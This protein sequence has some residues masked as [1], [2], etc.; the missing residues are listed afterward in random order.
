MDVNYCNCVFEKRGVMKKNGRG[1]KVKNEGM[2]LCREI[3]RK[4]EEENEK[5]C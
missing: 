4:R 3:N 1:K 5:W 2:K